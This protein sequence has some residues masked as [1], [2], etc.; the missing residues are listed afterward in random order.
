MSNINAN[1]N[2]NSNTNIETLTLRSS[3]FLPQDGRKVQARIISLIQ[4]FCGEK[5]KKSNLLAGLTDEVSANAIIHGEAKN[6]IIRVRKNRRMLSILVLDNGT[7]FN[8]ICKKKHPPKQDILE[9]GKRGLYLVR[10]SLKKQKNMEIFWRR[11]P[12]VNAF[13]IKTEIA[14]N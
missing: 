7:T 12:T 13:A 10:H 1:S 5:C 3:D 6:I 9:P 2:T 8:P 11:F 14:M 4:D